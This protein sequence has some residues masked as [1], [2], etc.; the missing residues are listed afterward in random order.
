MH[1]RFEDNIY[2]PVPYSFGF[3]LKSLSIATTNEDWKPQFID[4][5]EEANRF[6]PLKKYLNLQGFAFYW[7]S[8][9]EDIVSEIS[10]EEKIYAK[11]SEI[12][13]KIPKRNYI[14]KPCN[15]NKSFNDA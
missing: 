4:R 3:L 10:S 1:I 13:K 8:K 5:T 9:E 12:S 15:N 2:Q 6:K 11:L 14:L 7:E